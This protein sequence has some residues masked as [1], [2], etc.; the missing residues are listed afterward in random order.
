M[1]SA[2]IYAKKKNEV[3]REIYQNAQ[4]D[5][6]T[7]TRVSSRHRNYDVHDSMTPKYLMKGK[8]QGLPDVYNYKEYSASKKRD[9]LIKHKY[10][11]DLDPPIELSSYDLQDVRP[12]RRASGNPK[13]NESEAMS[14]ALGFVGHARVSSGHSQ[15]EKL[16]GVDKQGR[17]LGIERVEYKPYHQ[18]EYKPMAGAGVNKV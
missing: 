6:D 7:N 9:A 4:S 11:S 16:C 10:V 8:A 17:L 3:L 15:I 2:D 18:P 12:H 5:S 14:R 1:N 13:N